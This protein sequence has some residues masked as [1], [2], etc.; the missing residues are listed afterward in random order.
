[1]TFRE[2]ASHPHWRARARKLA[3]AMRG[4]RLKSSEML[5]LGRMAFG[6]HEEQTRNV[7]AAGENQELYE[8]GGMWQSLVAAEA[9]ERTGT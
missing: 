2:P 5:S 8:H 3:L 1:M 7:L 4:R 6:W 9:E